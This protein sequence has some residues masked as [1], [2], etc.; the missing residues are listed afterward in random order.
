MA[1]LGTAWKRVSRLFG[2]LVFLGF[3]VF[4]DVALGFEG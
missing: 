1:A 3:G 2:V 4:E